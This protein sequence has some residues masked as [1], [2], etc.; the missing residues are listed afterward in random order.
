[1]RASDV[2]KDVVSV[3][4]THVASGVDSIP[5]AGWDLFG[6]TLDAWEGLGLQLK[7]EAGLNRRPP[8]PQMYGVYEI[9]ANGLPP[10]QVIEPVVLLEVGVILSDKSRSAS[11]LC[12]FGLRFLDE[13]AV[14]I[15]RGSRRPFLPN[16][17]YRAPR[18]VAG[19]V[20][21]LDS[22]KHNSSWCD[23]RNLTAGLK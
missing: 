11:K 15:G 10:S 23:H 12:G 20:K 14:G 16:G 9:E 19:S 18:L 13:E 17:D 21:T 1:M 7:L 8:V 6:M 5:Y 3:S 2:F 22:L 4:F